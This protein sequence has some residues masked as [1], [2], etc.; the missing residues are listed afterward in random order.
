MF[1]TNVRLWRESEQ[2][3]ESI[4]MPCQTVDIN[5]NVL[6][7]LSTIWQISWKLHLMNKLEQCGRANKLEH[8]TRTYVRP[9]S[10]NSKIFVTWNLKFSEIC[11]GTS[12][13]NSPIIVK[14]KKHLFLA[15]GCVMA[16]LEH[17]IKERARSQILTLHMIIEHMFVFIIN[18]FG[19]NLK[20][21]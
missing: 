21:E 5:S 10:W 20:S 2:T 1:R 3:F 7:A 8:V 6:G 16:K 14:K 15:L 4:P 19:R 17:V 18:F 13:K 12:Y 9:L 11:R